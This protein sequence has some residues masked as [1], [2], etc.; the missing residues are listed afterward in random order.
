[1]GIFYE[2]YPVTIIL[3][4][5]FPFSRWKK[6]GSENAFAQLT[7]KLVGRGVHRCSFLCKPVTFPWHHHGTTLP[8]CGNP[9]GA[10]GR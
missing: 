6:R 10:Q 1:M 2:D 3:F 8:P 7:V 4:F 9:W 5:F